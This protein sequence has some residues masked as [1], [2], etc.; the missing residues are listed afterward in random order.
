M[1][2][3]NMSSKCSLTEIGQDYALITGGDNHIAITG[4]CYSVI[5]GGWDAKLTAGD[6]ST[7]VWRVFDGHRYR[8]YVAYVGENGIKP[9]TPYMF[10]NGKIVE[11]N[12]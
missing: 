3:E 7:L 5:T 12:P 6:R 2:V 8:I 11:A 9:N 1:D 4:G 10:R